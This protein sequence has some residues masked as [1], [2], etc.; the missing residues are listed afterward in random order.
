MPSEH[1]TPVMAQTSRRLILSCPTRSTVS[2]EGAD[3]SRSMK[4]FARARIDST[5]SAFSGNMSSVTGFQASPRP[6]LVFHCQSP[7]E[8]S[9]SSSVN[10]R[11][12]FG[13]NAM[14]VRA[15]SAARARSLEYAR[16]TRSPERRSASFRACS[17]PSSFNVPGKWPWRIPAS[18]STV[19][20]CRVRMIFNSFQLFLRVSVF[21]L[22]L[23][24]KRESRTGKVFHPPIALMAYVQER[25]DSCGFC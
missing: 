13:W 25:V 21:L 4:P 14:I 5:D 3:T 7:S 22:E 10:S 15:V 18:F 1:S 6:S 16:S 2:S 11:A 23:H 12:T 20:P 17:F 19:R 8:A 24:Y 9:R